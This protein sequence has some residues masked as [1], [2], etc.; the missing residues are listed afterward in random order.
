MA[1]KVVDLEP[2]SRIRLQALISKHHIF[3]F[4]EIHIPDSS[5][6]ATTATSTMSQLT[7]KFGNSKSQPGKDVNNNVPVNANG[8]DQQVSSLIANTD[9]GKSGSVSYIQLQANFQKATVV[10]KK[11]GQTVVT[12]SASKDYYDLGSAVPV[13]ELVINATS[14]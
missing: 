11:K 14:S 3:H 12:L 6:T 4:Y 5:D 2:T 8:Q 9:V 10:V 13:G 1:Y 7:I